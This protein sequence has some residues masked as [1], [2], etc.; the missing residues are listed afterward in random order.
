MIERLL[1]QLG[2][3]VGE[4]IID[5]RCDRSAVQLVVVGDQIREEALEQVD[6]DKWLD[7]T[8]GE[9]RALV[10]G[11]SGDALGHLTVIGT[12]DPGTG[13]PVHFAVPTLPA[14]RDV[15][16]RVFAPAYQR[17][18]GAEIEP[19]WRAA[20]ERGLPAAARS[21]EPSSTRKILRVEPLG[22]RV[23]REPDWMYFVRSDGV[24]RKGR[25]RPG[26]PPSRPEHVLDF[27]IH[28]T[29]NWL[30]FVDL[31]GQLMRIPTYQT[32]LLIRYLESTDGERAELI[33]D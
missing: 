31:D 25:R 14:Y 21:S 19:S 2:A 16:Q 4:R 33:A 29:E 22:P 27:E 10:R 24:Y 9:P 32:G 8:E 1:E 28:D 7:G 23:Q 12:L 5:G 13:E 15:P 20:F 3:R 30:Y 26:A 6:L 11:P 18:D 17:E